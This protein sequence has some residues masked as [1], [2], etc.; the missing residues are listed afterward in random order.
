MASLN[1]L[2]RIRK[3]ALREVDRSLKSLDTLVEKSQRTI[4]RLR[5]RKVKV[6]EVA[7]LERLITE[8]SKMDTSMTDYSKTLSDAV[9]SFNV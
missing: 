7:D 8:A 9:A 4:K 1:E 6:P 2:I 5:S 3:S